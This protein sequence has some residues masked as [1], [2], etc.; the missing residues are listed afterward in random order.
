MAI[1]RNANVWS[2]TDPDDF[3]HIS[4]SH[5]AP[6]KHLSKRRCS[7]FGLEAGFGGFKI[8]SP[9]SKVVFLSNIKVHHQI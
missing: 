2:Y 7:N 6:L 9:R 3:D 5:H 4:Y 8:S 1:I